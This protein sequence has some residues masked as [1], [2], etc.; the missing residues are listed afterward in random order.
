MLL[1]PAKQDQSLQVMFM[2]K[3]GPTALNL[4]KDFFSQSVNS[5]ETTCTWIWSEVL[6]PLQ[7][8]VSAVTLS[9]LSWHD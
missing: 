7:T 9:D 3:F 1:E 6:F 4:S 2:G 8:I 5:F